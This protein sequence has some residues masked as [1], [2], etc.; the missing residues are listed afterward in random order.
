MYL[1]AAQ[2]LWRSNSDIILLALL[3]SGGSFIL[4]R[5]TNEARFNLDIGP[6]RNVV[7]EDANIIIIIVTIHE[8]SSI[9]M[10]RKGLGQKI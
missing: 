4:S 6:R 2:Q 10:N 3:L 7:E 5:P 9:K 8:S 1:G